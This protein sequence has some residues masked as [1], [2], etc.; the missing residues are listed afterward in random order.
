MSSRQFDITQHIDYENHM[1]DYIKK[2]QAKQIIDN[3]KT[4][5]GYRPI[6]SHPDYPALMNMLEQQHR[7][8]MSKL[9][10]EMR[11]KTQAPGS[12]NEI[13][14]H[15]DYKTVVKKYDEQI[16][17]LTRK[18]ALLQSK[19]PLECPPCSKC[20]KCAKCPT[21]NKKEVS[22]TVD[23]DYTMKDNLIV[24]EPVAANNFPP[25]EVPIAPSW[26][27]WIVK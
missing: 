24:G 2:T 13:T 22:R 1:K 11:R 25:M 12:I 20:P 15:P 17:Q 19:R 21:C 18:I 5:V 9:E 8:N 6:Q 16:A 10:Q 27:N 3:L 7:K 14:M 26:G 23:A 4:Q